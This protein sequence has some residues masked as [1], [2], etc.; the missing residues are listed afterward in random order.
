WPIGVDDNRRHCFPSCRFV[1][2]RKHDGHVGVLAGGD[3]LFDAIED[4]IRSIGFGPGRNRGGVRSR[5][6][7]AQAEAPD[8]FAPR[9]RLEV[10]FLLRLVAEPQYRTA[11]DRTLVAQSRRRRTVAPRTFV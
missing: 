4:E 7:L 9:K 11:A 3:E 5:M 8:L 1:G 10:F 2:D 6:R